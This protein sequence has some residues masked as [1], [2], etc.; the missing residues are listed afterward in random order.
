[1]ARDEFDELERLPPVARAKLCALR[2]R[3]DATLALW[4]DAQRQLQGD[5]YQGNSLYTEKE[6]WEARI[7]QLLQPQAMEAAGGDH[8]VRVPLLHE[9]EVFNI[10]PN[11]IFAPLPSGN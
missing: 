4:R 10:R 7:A 9:G 2:E 5:P 1:M 11:Y 6:R 3:R 8:Q